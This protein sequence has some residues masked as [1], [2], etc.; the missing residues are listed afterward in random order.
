M[1][2][3]SNLPQTACGQGSEG[4]WGLPPT[5]NLLTW[6][7]EYQDDNEALFKSDVNR[8]INIV[9]TIDV[10]YCSC[11]KPGYLTVYRCQYP[12]HPTHTAYPCFGCY[13]DY[14]TAR[15]DLLKYHPDGKKITTVTA[16]LCISRIAYLRHL[17]LTYDKLVPVD[18][19][20][21][22]PQTTACLWCLHEHQ[23]HDQCIGEII[24]LL[25][26]AIPGAI[27]WSLIGAM[28][29]PTDI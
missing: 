2:D 7:G 16:S 11:G 21:C 1:V 6:P 19:P 15:N 23:I 13:Y 9:S 12:S 29:M 25:T 28:D 5:P 18:N 8:F 22:Y 3:N 24:W 4:E 26:T 27:M 20:T 10:D 17:A 14:L